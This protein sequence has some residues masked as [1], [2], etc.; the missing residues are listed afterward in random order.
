V[1]SLVEKRI[2][3]KM[4]KDKEGKESYYLFVG[5][6]VPGIGNSVPTQRRACR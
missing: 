2:K 6:T 3:E 4:G 1:K 5:G